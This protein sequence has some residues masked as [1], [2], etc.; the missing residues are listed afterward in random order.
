MVGYH[1][2]MT[3]VDQSQILLDVLKEME[4]EHGA[5]IGKLFGTFGIDGVGELAAFVTLVIADEFAKDP[6]WTDSWLEIKNSI[7]RLV[8]ERLDLV[9]YFEVMTR[10]DFDLYGPSLSPGQIQKGHR[11]QVQ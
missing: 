8:W 5:T 3:Q 1:D 7:S 6:H 11:P 4:T 2:G 10:S 9:S